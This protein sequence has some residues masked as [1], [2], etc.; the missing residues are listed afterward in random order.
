MHYAMVMHEL[1]WDDN[2][3][4][5]PQITEAQKLAYEEQEA[6]DREYQESLE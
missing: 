6:I 3:A 4:G 2:P 1:E 5:K